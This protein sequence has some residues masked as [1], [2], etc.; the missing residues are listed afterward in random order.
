M[1]HL[2][3]K[4]HWWCTEQYKLFTVKS[5]YDCYCSCDQCIEPQLINF[6]QHLCVYMQISK[7]NYYIMV[8]TIIRMLLLSLMQSKLSDISLLRSAD[9]VSSSLHMKSV[10]VNS[11]IKEVLAEH[12]DVQNFTDH[13]MEWLL[14]LM[15]LN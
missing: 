2:W 14:W 13:H 12:C 1:V 11:K 9:H 15:N 6:C 10:Q 4:I 7:K 5:L 8:V 3:Y